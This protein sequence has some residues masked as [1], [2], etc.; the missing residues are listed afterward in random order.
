MLFSKFTDAK[1]LCL[2]LRRNKWLLSKC[3]YVFVYVCG[4]FVCEIMQA[5]VYIGLYIYIYRYIGYVI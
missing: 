3:K 5:K 1:I 4:K 2:H